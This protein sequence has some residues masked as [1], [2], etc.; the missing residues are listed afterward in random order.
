VKIWFS[1]KFAFSNGFN[2]CRYDSGVENPDLVVYLISDCYIG[3][4]QE[5]DVKQWVGASGGGVSEEKEEAPVVA[6][7][8]GSSRWGLYKLNAVV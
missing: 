7:G 2:L 3:L 8:S 6:G 4:D 1:T 5:V